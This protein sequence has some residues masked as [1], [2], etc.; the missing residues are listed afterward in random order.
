MNF[1]PNL[2]GSVAY[3]LQISIMASE[4]VICVNCKH[5]LMSILMGGGGQKCIWFDA[6]TQVFGVAN[7]V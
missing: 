2:C 1:E 7:L 3:K 5:I 6:L 4:R